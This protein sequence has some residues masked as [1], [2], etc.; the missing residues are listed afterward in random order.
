MSKTI[1]EEKQRF[2]SPLSYIVLGLGFVVVT[3]TTFFSGSDNSIKQQLLSYLPFLLILAF[4]FTIKLKT[5]IDE[6]GIHIGFFPF[7]I[8]VKTFN[9]SDIYSAKA[10]EYS[11][12]SE[13]GGWGYRIKFTK[14]AKAFSTRGDKGIKVVL[15][16]GRTR[17]I[18]TQKMEEANT[19][20]N[21]FIDKK[22]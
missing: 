9:W 22:V 6:N 3:Y 20:I 10:E 21:Q 15:K 8:K 11:P 7:I 17:M 13:Y 16:D 19:C 4:L 2:D 12:I 18:G 14:K 1:F 5:R